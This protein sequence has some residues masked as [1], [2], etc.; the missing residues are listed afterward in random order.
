MQGFVYSQHEILAVNVALSADRPL[1]V[2][3]APG[4]GKSSLALGIARTLSATLYTAQ[5]RSRSTVSDLSYRFDQQR[6][7]QDERL[8]R[9]T[10]SVS[11]Y[12]EP[13]V[14]WWAFDPDSARLR[15]DSATPNELYVADPG[16]VSTNLAPSAVLL[17]EGI[18]RATDD[19][20][21]DLLEVMA[22]KEFVVRDIA[23]RVRAKRPTLFVLESNGERELPGPL[24]QRCVRLALPSPDAHQLFR[25]GRSHFPDM[26]EERLRR[27]TDEFVHAQMSGDFDASIGT[28]VDILRTTENLGVD[29]GEAYH[30]VFHGLLQ[31]SISREMRAVSRA[32]EVVAPP[33]PLTPN[34]YGLP[35]PYRAEAARVARPKKSTARRVKIFLSYRR[36]DSAAM[37]GRIYDHLAKRYGKEDVFKDVD[38]V[39]YGTDFVEFLEREVNKCD[40]FFAVIGPRWMGSG[41]NGRSRLQDPND[42][43][44]IEIA[45]ALRRSIL[46][47]PILVDGA[48]IPPESQLPDDIKTLVRR[49]GIS[50]RHD[51]DFHTDMK[52]LTSRLR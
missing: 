33:L 15:G 41:S 44:R 37:A 23:F 30:E 29:S 22:S 40:V 43:V 14:L 9:P 28:Y 20:L 51:P 25:I 26:P 32:E 52:R 5:L 13:A 46:V 38:S 18:E 11:R 2:S 45:A 27:V 16:T 21:L 34:S 49:N 8:G 42:F 6:A 31:P 7:S 50:V 48:Q 19:F 17:L 12:I 36:D 10:P 24:L 4:S 39:P 3:G 35:E 1:L 47:V